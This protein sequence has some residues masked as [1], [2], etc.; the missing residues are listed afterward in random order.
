[1]HPYVAFYFIFVLLS[2][3]TRNEE[4]KTVLKSN[5]NQ[6]RLPH[7][8]CNEHRNR[9]SRSQCRTRHRICLNIHLTGLP[10]IGRRVRSS[11]Q[12]SKEA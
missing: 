4:I 9:V 1:M 11:F 12:S 3:G 10:G 6:L 8:N 2:L 7:L 5:Y